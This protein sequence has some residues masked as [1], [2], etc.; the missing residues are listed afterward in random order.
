MKK[1]LILTVASA[2]MLVS[3]ISIASPHVV[4]SVEEMAGDIVFRE[5]PVSSLSGCPLAGGSGGQKAGAI[6]KVAASN[7]SG[8]N[9]NQEEEGKDDGGENQDEKQDPSGPDRL[10]D[11]P[12]QG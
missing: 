1:A 5:Q 11:A 9:G 4:H 2:A 8:E 12:K 6:I 7:G 10:W 3:Y